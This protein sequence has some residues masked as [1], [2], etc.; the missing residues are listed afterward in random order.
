MLQIRGERDGKY[1]RP[2]TFASEREKHLTERRS[3]WPVDH[4]SDTKRMGWHSGPGGEGKDVRDV[5]QLH[6]C[7]SYSGIP[8]A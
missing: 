1:A 7:P 8:V 3:D 4:G 6:K 2:Y 5:L